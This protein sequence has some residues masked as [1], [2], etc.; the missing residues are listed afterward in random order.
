MESYPSTGPDYE[1]TTAGGYL[2]K[3]KPSRMSYIVFQHNRPEIP[4]GQ[5]SMEQPLAN[6]GFIG[7]RFEMVHAVGQVVL[8]A[9]QG[10]RLT[11]PY[12]IKGENYNRQV[13]LASYS[14]ADQLPI[15]I[16]LFESVKQFLSKARS[17]YIYRYIVVDSEVPRVELGSL[18]IHNPEMQVLAVVIETTG[19]GKDINKIRATDVLNHEKAGDLVGNP[20]FLA[21]IYLRNLELDRLKEMLLQKFIPGGDI[22]FI[23]TFLQ[24][25]IKNEQHKNELDAVKSQLLVLDELFRFESLLDASDT[26]KIQQELEK[27][28]APNIAAELIPLVSRRQAVAKDHEHEILNWEWEYRLK[29]IAGVS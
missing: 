29:K 3:V 21:R 16:A 13:S 26:Q 27:G 18:K 8:A 15:R 5:S 20:V 22:Q 2:I 23:R 28:I 6:I 17:E 4:P 9:N 12:R 7:S 24:L 11:I 19:E 25:M 14:R 1:I 10:F